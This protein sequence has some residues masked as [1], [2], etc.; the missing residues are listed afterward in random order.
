MDVKPAVYEDYTRRLIAELETLVLVTPGRRQLVPQPR[1]SR[2]H[3][4]AVATGGLLEVD[5]PP[6][7]SGLHAHKLK[8]TR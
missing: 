8:A 4:L 5:A 7:L 3:H 2:G 1:G 6:D